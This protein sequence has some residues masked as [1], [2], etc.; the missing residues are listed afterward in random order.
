V[1]VCIGIT[2]IQQETLTPTDKDFIQTKAYQLGFEE[3]FRQSQGI[4]P[5][6]TSGIE[7]SR[8][9]RERMKKQKAREAQAQK[10]QQRC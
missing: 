5:S 8:T 9:A 7:Q 4:R 10:V 3:G 1:C 6:T 2:T